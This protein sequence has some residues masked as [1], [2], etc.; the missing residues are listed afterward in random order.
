MRQG[1]PRPDE[2]ARIGYCAA[3]KLAFLGYRLTIGLAAKE[4]AI[5]DFALTPANVHDGKTFPL[6]WKDLD[7]ENL[8]KWI[9]DVY[10]DNAYASTSNEAL[11]IADLKNPCFHANE[12]TGKHPKKPKQARKKSK[13]R[14]KIEAT[15][16]ILCLNY[17]LEHIRVRGLPRVRIEMALTMSLWNLILILAYV[18]DRFDDRWSIRKLYAQ[19]TI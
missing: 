17:N 10:G 3:K 13:I 4:G 18:E 14:S 5:L 16:G 11:V 1:K 7:Q 9:H 12:E 6:L 8:L 2:D 19:K 15:N